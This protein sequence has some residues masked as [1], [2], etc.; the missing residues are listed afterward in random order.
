M[1][2]PWQQHA[3]EHLCHGSRLHKSVCKAELACLSMKGKRCPCRGPSCFGKHV[4]LSTTMQLAAKSTWVPL[5]AVT[6]QLEH[7]C[8]TR[9]HMTSAP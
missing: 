7:A 5:A 9:T 2:M 3:I 1:M 6:K 8:K 4:S